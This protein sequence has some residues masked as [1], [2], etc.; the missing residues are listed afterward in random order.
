MTPFD[1]ICIFGYY[2]LPSITCQIWSF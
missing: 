1:L 2:L